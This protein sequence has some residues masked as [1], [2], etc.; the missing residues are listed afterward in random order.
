M[1]STCPRCNAAIDPN[2]RFCTNCGAVIASQEPYAQ[3]AQPAQPGQ[4][5]QLPP[6]ASSNPGAALYQQQGAPYQQQWAGQ[7]ANPAAGGS[8]GFGGSNDALAKK[9]ITWIVAGIAITIGL[10]ILFGL[11]AAFV[12]F[13]RGLF[14]LLLFVAIVVPFII[15]SMIRNYVRRTVGRLWWFL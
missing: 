1:N 5:A 6:W 7:Q 15:Y 13:L 14:C 9:V 10:L 8:L 12:P 2:S 4:A 3:P 11:L